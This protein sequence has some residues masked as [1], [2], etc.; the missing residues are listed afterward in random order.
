MR[1]NSQLQQ[2]VE[3]SIRQPIP[4]C[5]D[6]SLA[7]ELVGLHDSGAMWWPEERT[8][9]VSDLHLEKAASIAK[10]KG[11]MLPPYDTAATLEKLA[12]LVDL[13]DPRRVICLGDSFH[14]CD[15]SERMPAAYLAM[16]TTMQLGREWIWITGNHDPKIACHI[17]GERYNELSL[18][19]LNFR[20]E[21]KQGVERG[22]ICG[23]LH[24]AAKVRRMG[25][26]IRR[27]CFATNGN[28]L[29]LPAF[30]ALTGGLNVMD[31]A[32]SDIFEARRFSVFMLGNGRLFPFTASKLLADK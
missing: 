5:H 11:L 24:P 19:S 31:K 29:I 8:L 13:F 9:V 21:P 20:H 16:L 18:N 12:T 27:F 3:P 2:R 26:T 15:S 10:S 17:Q 14:D 30:G 22:E 25:R 32:F 6:L 23:H 28:R 1:P 7:R 4:V